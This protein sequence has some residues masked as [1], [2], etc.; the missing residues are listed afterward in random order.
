MFGGE[1]HSLVGEGKMLSFEP[2]LFVD[3][4]LCWGW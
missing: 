3:I 1:F 2:H 4:V